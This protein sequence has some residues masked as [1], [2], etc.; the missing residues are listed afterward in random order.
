MKELKNHRSKID[1][2]DEEILRAL[3][4]RTK[5]VLDIGKIKRGSNAKFY[6]PQR[7]REIINRLTSLNNGPFPNEALKTVYR[8]I[9]SASLALEETLKVACL[10]P[11]ATFAHLAAMRHFGSSASF[12]PL[13]TIRD[14]FEAV[15]TGQADFGVVP[16]ENSIEGFVSYT[17]DLFI[18]YDLKIASEVM[19][20]VSHNL[21]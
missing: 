21:L 15:D 1:S 4:K 2:I 14:V 9:L 7:E 17:L 16:I 13:G 8:E 5:V 20:E 10:G 6:S 19:L 11:V 3:N 12:L 18:D